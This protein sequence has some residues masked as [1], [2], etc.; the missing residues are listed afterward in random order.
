MGCFNVPCAVSGVD[1]TY[2]DTAYAVVAKVSGDRSHFSYYSDDVLKPVGIFLKGKYD[3]YGRLEEIENEELWDKY[4]ADNP[5]LPTIDDVFNR[6]YERIGPMGEFYTVLFV[7]EAAYGH[8]RKWWA[9]DEEI[10]KFITNMEAM[11]LIEVKEDD[12]TS[13]FRFALTGLPAEHSSYVSNL[14]NSADYDDSFRYV[15]H[16]IIDG[17]CTSASVAEDWEGIFMTRA[18]VSFMQ[19]INKPLIAFGAGQE[20]N[21]ECQFNV[22]TSIIHSQLKSRAEKYADEELIDEN[23][24]EKKLEWVP[25]ADPENGK[26]LWAEAEKKYM[27]LRYRNGETSSHYLYYEKDLIRLL[28]KNSNPMLDVVAYILADTGY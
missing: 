6:R 17:K 23:D 26:P 10:T 27:K 15:Y 24:E 11:K 3:D 20:F 28:F 22:L 7:S 2:G 25:V 18:L 13:R 4:R 21:S 14:Y 9:T 19:C 5:G 8:I 12:I 1:I 16:S